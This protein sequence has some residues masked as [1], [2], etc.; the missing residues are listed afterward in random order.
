[1]HIRNNITEVIHHYK[2]HCI[3]SYIYSQDNKLYL[4]LIASA[5]DFF[6]RL[7]D[8]TGTE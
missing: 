3:H 5:R 6:I 1:M 7:N 8:F 4:T 2:L